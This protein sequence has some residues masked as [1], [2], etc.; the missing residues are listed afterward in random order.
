MEEIMNENRYIVMINSK[1]I[2]EGMLL[3]DAILLIK[4]ELEEYNKDS[5]LVSIMKDENKIN[6]VAKEENR[7]S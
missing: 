2:A 3:Q 5:M 7:L 6:A 1:V 4:A